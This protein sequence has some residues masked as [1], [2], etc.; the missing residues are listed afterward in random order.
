[1]LFKSE[2]I[3]DYLLNLCK[4]KIK[5]NPFENWILSYITTFIYKF[6][7]KAQDL[8]LLVTDNYLPLAVEA[9]FM[10]GIPNT[11][12][13]KKQLGHNTVVLIFFCIVTVI[14]LQMFY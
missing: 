4:Q 5:F 9:L 11:N 7:Y 14:S 1:M 12:Y 8:I 2:N 6:C 3:E 10:F 13:F